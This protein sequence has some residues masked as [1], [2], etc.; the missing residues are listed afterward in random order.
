MLIPVLLETAALFTDFLAKN[1][2]SLVISPSCFN[3]NTNIGLSI[4]YSDFLDYFPDSL[5]ILSVGKKDKLFCK[6]L[7]GVL[8]LRGFA[9]VLA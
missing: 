1:E 8:A 3:Q 6:A 5:N 4:K 2:P 9:N 7:V